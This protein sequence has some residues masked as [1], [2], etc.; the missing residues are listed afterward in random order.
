MRRRL[1]RLLHVIVILSTLLLLGPGPITADISAPGAQPNA[2]E[3]AAYNPGEGDGYALWRTLWYG[4]GDLTAVFFL[5]DQHGWVTGTAGR[6]F[7]TVNGGRSW[8]MAQWRP[9]S[10][11]HTRRDNGP[12]LNDVVFVSAWEGWAVGQDGVII[13]TIDGGDTWQAQNSGVSTPLNA[14]AFAPDGLHGWAVGDNGVIRH[15]DDGG[16]TWTAQVSGIGYH[17]Y[18]VFALDGQRA[19]AV[20]Q[21]GHILATND[22]GQTWHKQHVGGPHLYAILFLPDGRTGWAVGGSGYVWATTDG[23]TTWT[24]ENAGSSQNLFAVTRDAA[25]NLWVAGA[26]GTVGKRSLSGSWQFW[27]IGTGERLNSIAVPGDIWLA[28]TT[29]TLLTAVSPADSWYNPLG[30]QLTYLGGITMPDGVHGWVVGKRENVPYDKVGVILRTEDGGWSWYA[31]EHGVASGYLNKVAAVD[32]NTAWVVG[33]YGGKILHTTDGGQT[34]T[35]QSIGRTNEITDIDCVDADRCW[36]VVKT[37]PGDPPLMARTTNGGATWNLWNMHGLFVQDVRLTSVD[38]EPDGRAMVFNLAGEHLISND[39]FQTIVRSNFV[40][41][42]HGQW[43]I[44]QYSPDLTFTAGL[45]G[46]VVRMIRTSYLPDLAQG[47][48]RRCGVHNG[49]QYCQFK[50]GGQSDMLEWFGIGMLDSRHVLAV[51]G[52]C[53]YRRLEGDKWVC[54]GFDGGLFGYTDRP[55]EIGTWSGD[56]IPVGIRGRL[57]DMVFFRTGQTRGPIAAPTPRWD[58]IAVGDDGFILGYKRLP[59]HLFAYPIDPV[60]NI[61]GRLTE[62]APTPG[63]DLSLRTA[64]RIS[65]SSPAN[66]IDPSAHL[67]ARRNGDTLY[68]G[69]W[70]T[71]TTRISDNGLPMADDGVRVAL[72]AAHDGVA[73]GTDDL[74]I[75][76]GADGTAQVLAGAA[77]ALQAAATSPTSTGYQVEI[78]INAA[79]LGATLDYE[80]TWGISFEVWDDDDGGVV[81]HVLGSDGPTAGES[82]PD[83]GELTILGPEISIQ[84]DAARWQKSRTT[85]ICTGQDLNNNNVFQ[86]CTTL[87]Y[88]QS[89]KLQIGPQNS[90]AALLWFDLSGLPASMFIQKAEVR[91]YTRSKSG[92]GTL[93]VSAHRLLRPWNLEE[94]TW[95]QADRD[96][97]WQA[98]GALGPTDYSATPEWTSTVIGPNGWYSWDITQLVR[99]WLSGAQENYGVILRSFVNGPSFGFYPSNSHPFYKGRRP[100]LR[101]YYV[102]PWPGATPPPTWTPTPSPTATPTATPTPVTSVTPTPT[103]SG[104]PP[105]TPTPTAT[106]SLTPTPTPTPTATPTWTFTPTATPSPTFTPSPTHTPSPTFTPTPTSAYTPTPTSTATPTLTPTPPMTGIVRGVVWEDR[107]LDRLVDPDE[108]RLSGVRVDLWMKGMLIRMATTL[109]DGS[110]RFSHLAPGTYRL[111]EHDPAGYESFSRNDVQVVLAAGQMIV[112][113]FGDVPEGTIHRIGIPYIRKR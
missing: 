73:G 103:S 98:P 3:G 69:I 31:Q 48:R 100:R 108:P 9:Q 20:G 37:N 95:Q 90:K 82:Q 96:T 26:F 19:W 28:G 43:D 1:P 72:D 36:A 84:N 24:R 8:H 83:M 6:I 56:P 27:S 39:F 76:V 23:G 110:Y 112:V 94:A 32:A 16:T 63:I 10:Q 25:G 92:T 21:N 2:A 65:F 42:N 22:G 86:D 17:L 59:H 52:H 41:S 47:D 44:D 7:R 102:I 93:N 109:A 38:V 29:M 11:F 74:V 46:Q 88:G 33:Q 79:A 70:V 66:T 14:V 15:T 75:W 55:F 61:D 49:Y 35:V 85:Y 81:E 104:T 80:P 50:G 71:D 40:G 106:P 45:F 53:A 58:A 30:G 64:D 67:Q 97:A 105:V 91:L 34:W 60:P 5:D 77:S 107:D 4:R 78:A 68:I 89:G 57:R 13:H 51:G 18:D 87:N 111:V 99:D 101:I 54:A 113:N 62:W 12:Q